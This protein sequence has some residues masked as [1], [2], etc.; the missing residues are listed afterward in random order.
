MQLAAILLPGLAF[1]SQILAAVTAFDPSEH[2][3]N[4]ARSFEAVTNNVRQ[5]WPILDGSGGRNVVR[6]CYADAVSKAKLQQD[7]EAAIQIWMTALGGAASSTAEHNLVF[8]EVSGQGGEEKFCS[9]WYQRLDQDRYTLIWDASSDHS[10]VIGYIPPAQLVGGKLDPP[11]RHHMHLSTLSGAHK[12]HKYAHEL[13]HVLALV[14]EHQRPDRDQHVI[15]RC[16]KVRGFSDAFQ[17]ARYDPKNDLKLADWEIENKLCNEFAFA[18]RY[19]FF[20]S[21]FDTEYGGPTQLQSF[22]L[23]DYDT[24]SIMHYDSLTA[25]TYDL[26]DP[27]ACPNNPAECAIVRKGNGEPGEPIF[28]NLIP[29]AGDLAFVR[30][31]Y[32]Y[33]RRP[34]G[35]GQ[36]G[37]LTST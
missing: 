24:K 31:Y 16:H 8:A 37:N 34:P 3:R 28:T 5:T 10:A 26:N 1:V 2:A 20:G 14:H 27:H 4:H 19:G 35:G 29:S 15:Y 25:Q 11:N 18:K 21:A 32:P 36:A 17:K 30:T 13:G 22:P 23:G 7:F 12:I 33:D 6:Y 9:A